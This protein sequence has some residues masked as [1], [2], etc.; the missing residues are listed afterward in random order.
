MKLLSNWASVEG[1][2]LVKMKSRSFFVCIPLLL[3][4]GLILLSACHP[5]MMDDLFAPRP[6][7]EIRYNCSPRQE[8]PE[9]YIKKICEYLNEKQI[10]V[11]RNAAL[12]VAEITEGIMDGR[13]VIIVRF[14]CCGTGDTAAIDKETGEVIGYNKGIY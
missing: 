7:G 3:I 4:V 14:T 1:L 13:E 11:D 9:G 8:D 5:G 6:K 10:W 2:R 12:E